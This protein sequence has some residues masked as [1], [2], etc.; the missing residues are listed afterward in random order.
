[1]LRQ[2][3]LAAALTLLLAHGSSA[4]GAGPGAGIADQMQSLFNTMT[5]ATEPAAHLGQRRGAFSGGSFVARN[6]IM[7]ESLWSVVPPSFEAGCGGIDLFA[8]SFSFISGAQFQQLLRSIAANA[9]GYAFQVALENMCPDCMRQLSDLQKKLQALNQGFANSCQLAKGIVNDVA[10][11]FDLKHKDDTSLLAMVKGV[12]DVF[13]TRST[14]SGQGPIEAAKALPA[15][16]RAKLQ[17]NLVWQALKRRGAAGAFVGGDDTLLEAIMSVSGTVIVGLPEAAPDGQGDNHRITYLP[18]N[19]ISASDLLNGTRDR[20]ALARRDNNAALRFRMY[21]CDDRA[22]DAC[23]N[24]VAREDT[25]A[26]MTQRVKDVLIGVREWQA[27]AQTQGMVQ[28]FRFGDLPLTAGRTG[29]HGVCPQRHRPA[30]PHPGAPGRRGG[31][32]LRGRGRA[33]DRPG[34][35]QGDHERPPRR[36]PPG[37]GAQRTCLRQAPGRADRPGPPAARCRVPG[38]PRP[39][40]QSPDAARPLP[41]PQGGAAGAATPIRRRLLAEIPMYEIYSIGDGAYLTAVL[42]AVAMLSGS[43]D[44]QQLAGVGFLMGILL[45]MGQGILQAKFPPLQNVLFAWVLYMAMFGPTARVQVEDL[46]SGATR[47]VDNVPLGVAFVGSAMSKVGYGVTVLFEQAFSTPAM[48]EYGFAAPLQILQDTRKGTW[49]SVAQG[50]ANAPTPG[51]DMER[52]W[53][54]YIA[55]CVL[56]N[57][58][59]GRVARDT[60]VRD[61]SWPSAFDPHGLVVPTVQLW[62][63]G[64]PVTKDCRAAWADLRDYTTTAYTPALRRSLAA[65][66][67]IEEGNVD[68]TI[69]A[70]LDALAGMGSD[71]QDYMVMAA[72]LPFWTKGKADVYRELGKY[73]D[74]VMVEQAA[75]QRNTQWAAEERLFSKIVRPMM[76]FFEAF[77]FAI[78]PLM[79]FAIGLGPVGIRMVG[80]Y[81]MFALWIQLW[82]PILAVI[83]LYIIMAVQGKLDAL[84]AVGTGDTPLPSLLALWKL[85]LILADYLGTGGMLA[86]ST[87]AISLM[88]IYGSAITATH[89]AGRLQGGD[90]INEKIASPD[91]LQPAPALTMGPLQ[92]HTRLSGSVT[93]DAHQ[94]LPSIN[95]ASSTEQSVRSA[96]TEQAQSMEAFRSALSNAAIK[97]AGASSSSGSGGSRAWNVSA[98][99][100]EVDKFIH[101][102]AET[103]RQ[104]LGLGESSRD[105]IA[106]AYSAGLHVGAKGGSQEDVRGAAR[107]SMKSPLKCRW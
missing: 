61:P 16:D 29:L 89:L 4:H 36:R 96:Q 81:L 7:N 8:G 91:V 104:E 32:D 51:A 34:D 39:S 79:M 65:T 6:R 58:D 85:D 68:G 66:L 64:A 18:G 33:G 70:A 43:G 75:Q 55:G 48:T 28:K 63:G 42:N 25:V 24:P 94:V 26:G 14:A 87:P 98:G 5:N 46:Y 9:P 60:I 93:P 23:L 97:T 57:V 31:A 82:K 47:H 44:M 76:T 37:R 19:L 1:M 2:P 3:L 40:R 83:N 84:Q 20:E 13:E 10:S 35:D 69:Q 62:L 99:T 15:A 73:N 41:A 72:L 78:S 59:T 103:I 52:S 102:R 27:G 49:S 17:G 71:A 77:L 11:A 21:Q 107:Q 101:Q 67:R 38:A 50:A 54:A 90:H 74:A 45:V 53:S 22:E 95:L 88:L 100:S 56:W 105:S 92:A 80:K 86:A 12:G 106:S 30:D